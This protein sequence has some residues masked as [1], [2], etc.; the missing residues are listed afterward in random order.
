MTA[1]SW[2]D[3][4][5]LR[6]VDG[7]TLDALVRVPI[8]FGGWV[9]LP[10]RLR[11]ARINAPAASTVGGGLARAY[12]ISLLPVPPA[13]VNLTTLKPYKYGGVD[14]QVGDWVA[15]VTLPDGRNVSDEMVTAGHAAPWNG[16]GSRPSDG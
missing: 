3:S 1:W 4:R 11:L 9:Q 15:E 12:L 5:I 8:G 10:V 2:P 7:D 13:T 6:V 16:S 14:G